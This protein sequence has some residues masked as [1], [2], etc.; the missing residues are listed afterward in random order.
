MNRGRNTLVLL[1]VAAA[2]GAYVYFVESKHT[3]ASEAA[4]ETRAKVFD[5][6]DASKI[7]A[8]TIR[9]SAGDKT[10]LKK[11]GDKWQI[12]EPVQSGADE[13]EMSGLTSNL[14]TL[15][16]SR[17]VDQQPK[18][19]SK[20]GLAPQPR[21]EVE[22]TAAG[23]K[24]PKKLL[25]GNKTATGGDLYAKL[26]NENKVMLIPAYLDTT[27]DRTTFALRDKSILKFDRDKV[28]TVEITASAAQAAAAGATAAADAKGGKGAK[29]AGAKAAAAMKAAAAAG[30]PVTM[31]FVKQG[32]SWKMTSPVAARTDSGAVDGVLGKLATGQMKSLTEQDAGTNAAD[33]AKYGLAKPA[34]AVTLGVGNS[35]SELMIGKAADNGDLYAKDASRPMVFTVEKAVGNDIKTT[36]ADYRTKDLFEAKSFTTSRLEVKRGGQTTVFEKQKTKEKDDKGKEKDGPEKWAQTSPAPAKAVDATKIEDAV[37]KLVA[38]RADSFADKLPAGA[39]E[40]ATVS[41]KFEDGK[42][43]ENVVLYKAGS[44][45]Y[46][47]RADDAGAAKLATATVEDAIKSLDAAKP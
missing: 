39:T 18:D 5:K 15:E 46:A 8:I 20:Y 27:F 25:I 40:L 12:V 37:G 29:D 45:Y 38:L 32:E 7:D 31:K 10:T 34:I 43:S 26:A 1:I 6:L 23:D 36:P 47:T 13:T 30:P 42:R 44:D 33:L 28:D 3:P 17:V 2:L 21:V 19:L 35:H 14:G 24:N 11:A 41:T 4:V 16:V 22:F 9:G